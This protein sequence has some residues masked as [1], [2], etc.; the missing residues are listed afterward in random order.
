MQSA[1]SSRGGST[2]ERQPHHQIEEDQ[3]QLSFRLVTDL[4][5]L[6]I[7]VISAVFIC[8]YPDFLTIII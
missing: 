2:K 4:Q 7:N 1:S 6:G 5:G 8:R 3:E